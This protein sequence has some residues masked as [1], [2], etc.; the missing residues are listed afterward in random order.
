M[1]EPHLKFYLE[2]DPKLPKNDAVSASVTPTVEYI[3]EHN[4]QYVPLNSHSHE[5]VCEIIALYYTS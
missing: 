2:P 5:K 4:I 1:P 3:T